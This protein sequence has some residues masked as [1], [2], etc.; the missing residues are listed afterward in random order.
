[1]EETLDPVL[2][3]GAECEKVEGAGMLRKPEQEVIP[4]LTAVQLQESI[5]GD[6]EN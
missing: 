5:H 3:R 1:L 2:L 6:M 4:R